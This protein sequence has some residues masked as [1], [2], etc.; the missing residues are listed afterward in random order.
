MMMRD[1]NQ[2]VAQLTE[3]IDLTRVSPLRILILGATYGYSGMPEDGL[4]HLAFAER[5]SPG[6]R[7]ARPIVA[8]AI[9]PASA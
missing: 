3:T 9:T 1:F 5:L 2:A 7:R 6:C 8:A 4:R